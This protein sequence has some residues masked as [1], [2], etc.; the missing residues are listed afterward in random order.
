M[1]V[2]KLCSFKDSDAKLERDCQ[3]MRRS[4]K[5]HLARRFPGPRVSPE[6]Q[7]PQAFHLAE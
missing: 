3:V 4:L 2:K 1:L 7:P 6:A 5:T